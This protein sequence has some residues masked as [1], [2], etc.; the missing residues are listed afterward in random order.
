MGKEISSLHDRR[1][2]AE[3]EA[4]LSVVRLCRLGTKSA[5]PPLVPERA[6]AAPAA[7]LTEVCDPDD[8]DEEECTCQ[9]RRCKTDPCKGGCGCRACNND[10]QDFL[11]SQE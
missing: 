8:E 10:Y 1:R 11:S 4:K 9:E 2:I 5:Q 3:L 6:P 7:Q